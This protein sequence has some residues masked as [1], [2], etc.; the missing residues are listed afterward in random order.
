MSIALDLALF[1]MI[2]LSIPYGTLSVDVTTL[3]SF[4]ANT[5]TTSRPALSTYLWKNFTPN[6]NKPSEDDG[7]IR[8]VDVRISAGIVRGYVSYVAKRLAYVFKGIPIAE[9]PVGKLRFQKLRPLMPWSNV[10]NATKY[11]HACPSNTSRTLSPTKDWDEDCI[12]INVFADPKCRKGRVRCPVL[13]YIH[14]GGFITDSAVMFNETQI[15]QK[16][17]SDEVIFVL[18]AFRLGVLGFL[19]LGNDNIVPRNLGF[20]DIIFALNWTR[21]EIKSFGGDPNK[22]TA[23]G[24]SSGGSA[25]A[26][27]LES[28]KVSQEMF[29]QGIITSGVPFLTNNGNRPQTSAILNQFKCFINETTNGTFSDA[30]KVDCLRNVSVRELIDTQRYNEDEYSLLFV[31]PETDTDLF[32]GN[33]LADMRT[34]YK[35]RPLLITTTSTEKLPKDPID[36]ECDKAETPFGYKT[37][38]VHQACI[39]RYNNTF[40]SAEDMLFF[41]GLHWEPVTYTLAEQMMDLY[42]PSMIKNFLKTGIPDPDWLQVD[43][44]GNNY[45]LLDFQSRNNTVL[46]K[47]HSDRGLEDPEAVKFWLQDASILEEAEKKLS[48]QVQYRNSDDREGRN[49]TT[50][51][52]HLALPVLTYEN[53]TLETRDYMPISDPVEG[54]ISSERASMFVHDTVKPM[55]ELW[56]AFWL[57]LTTV[58]ILSTVIV[59]IGIRL[60][61]QYRNARGYSSP[62]GYYTETTQLVSKSETTQYT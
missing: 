2:I 32:P 31:G 6:I 38:A 22:I 56:S 39:K 48:E 57:S 12:Y 10:W 21:R 24:T 16:Y 28:P 23:M 46:I 33:N 62:N 58:F 13:F 17:A 35:A 15:V 41:F 7:R 29:K 3:P 20:Y 59:I 37:R 36:V 42:Y 8:F 4:V 19:D 18:P 11:R 47:P 45:F 55:R 49:Y 1:W 43:Q 9:P 52:S 61:R 51:H 5:I 25:V 40:R 44:S 14:G 50:H 26:Y 27:L 60:L 30:E 53:F 34:D 54:L